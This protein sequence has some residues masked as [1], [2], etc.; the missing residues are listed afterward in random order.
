MFIYGQG[1][2]GEGKWDGTINFTEEVSEFLFS[3]G[4]TFAKITDAVASKLYT[5]TPIVFTASL[6]N[7][8]F[9]GGLTFANVKEYMRFGETIKD[10]VFNV[11]NADK[12]TYDKYVSINNGMF[13]LKQIYDYR[14]TEQ[15]IDSGKMCSVALDYTGITV[16]SVVVNNG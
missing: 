10:Y 11:V 5:P 14:S 3:G 4:L 13:S 1:V 16:E 2:A 7:T 15:A 8:S 9:S 6:G 12:Y